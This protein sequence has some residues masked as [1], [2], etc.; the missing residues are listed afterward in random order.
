MTMSFDTKKN[1][2]E[3]IKA[4]CH[5][6]DKT[7]R[8]QILDKVANPNYYSIISNFSKKNRNSCIVK[9]KLKSSW[10]SDGIKFK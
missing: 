10:K 4:G 1:N 9:Y 7:V 8:P 6:Y 5:P 2:F 3:K